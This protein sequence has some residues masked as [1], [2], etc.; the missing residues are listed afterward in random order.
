M[1]E[2][3]KAKKRARCSDGGRTAGRRLSINRQTAQVAVS[4]EPPKAILSKKVPEATN[5]SEDED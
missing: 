3:R 5:K 1:G 2:A 4:G